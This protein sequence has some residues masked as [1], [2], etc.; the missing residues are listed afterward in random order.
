L[1]GKVNFSRRDFLKTGGAVVVSFSLFE[2]GAR[3]F[4]QAAAHIDPY[5]SPDYLDPRFLDSWL[6]I[7][8]DGTIKN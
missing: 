5:D 3:C 2:H 4:S 8:P 1:V 6:A 7:L